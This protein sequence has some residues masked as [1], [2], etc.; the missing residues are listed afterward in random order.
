M[1][2]SFPELQL[3]LWLGAKC[4]SRTKCIVIVIVLGFNLMG[5]VASEKFRIFDELWIKTRIEYIIEMWGV[6]PNI[7]R[8]NGPL[9]NTNLFGWFRVISTIY[10]K[11]ELIFFCYIYS[12]TT[13]YL[14]FYLHNVFL[15]RHPM[16]RRHI[17][18]WEMEIDWTKTKI[19]KT[20]IIYSKKH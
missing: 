10:S 14:W 13:I 6:L 15:I 17:C 1:N 2:S 5:T 20:N 8:M 19:T 12:M 4:N 7:H 11:Y 18:W 9:L 3:S 16:K